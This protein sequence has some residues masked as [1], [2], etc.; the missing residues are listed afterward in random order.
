MTLDASYE[1]SEGLMRSMNRNIDALIAQIMSKCL[2]SRCSTAASGFLGAI[3]PYYRPV[4]GQLGTPFTSVRRPIP[5]YSSAKPTAIHC[6][7][8]NPLGTFELDIVNYMG[9]GE[10]MAIW[11]GRD[12][13][14]KVDWEDSF[15]MELE[16]ETIGRRAIRDLD[17]SFEVLAHVTR[18]GNVV[19]LMMEAAQGRMVEYRD[20]VKVYA[21]FRLMEQ[22][23]IVEE[24]DIAESNIMILEGK[25][26][27]L[28][29]HRLRV[30]LNSERDEMILQARYW[31][32]RGLELLFESLANES[33]TLAPLRLMTPTLACRPRTLSSIPGPSNHASNGFLPRPT[34]VLACCVV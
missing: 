6:T 29:L 25:M 27:L 7:T 9:F 24:C 11:N 22:H 4:S 1:D 3:I 16:R 8:S 10:R 30:Y 17:I 2:Q 13:D 18:E 5:L 12:V 28:R 32:W 14:L 23:N 31:H 21:A 34:S 33:N 15:P 26:R 20:R 19:G